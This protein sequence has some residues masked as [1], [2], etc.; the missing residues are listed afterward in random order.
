MG[1]AVERALDAWDDRIIERS[2]YRDQLG[3]VRV[4]VDVTTFD[5]VRDVLPLVRT[6]AGRR[7][8]MGGHHTRI[9][10]RSPAGVLVRRIVAETFT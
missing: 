2:V 7:C 4:T 3:H 9:E 5:Q 10:Y 8:G 1:I 6:V